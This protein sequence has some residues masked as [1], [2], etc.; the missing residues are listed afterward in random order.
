[1]EVADNDVVDNERIDAGD[2]VP[3]V[4]AEDS[5]VGDGV[6]CLGI[7][8]VGSPDCSGISS[9]LQSVVKTTGSR[10][11]SKSLTSYI[12]RNQTESAISC[13]RVFRSAE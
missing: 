10:M 13:R 9:S 6:D 1:M 5:N 8:S 12:P 3:R 4:D 11:Y 2:K 7:A